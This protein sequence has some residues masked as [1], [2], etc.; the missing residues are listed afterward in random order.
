MPSKNISLNESLS[1]AWQQLQQSNTN[2]IN[3]MLMKFQQNELQLVNT[4][5]SGYCEMVTQLEQN[6]IMFGIIVIL[7]KDAC[8]ENGDDNPTNN[9]SVRR[10]YVFFT[11]TGS[12]VSAF[13]TAQQAILGP[14]IQALFPG[15]S[16]HMEA[17]ASLSSFT[18]KKIALRLL[19]SN[20]AHAPN[21]IHFGPNDEHVIADLIG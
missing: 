1:N 18:Q 6:E 20:G 4:G 12:H 21:R 14:E 19:Q 9:V 15:I 2:G 13:Q 3:W 8:S 16:I 17:D 10:R 7:A 11:F 5:K